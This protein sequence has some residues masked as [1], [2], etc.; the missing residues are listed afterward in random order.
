M[1][2]D[3]ALEAVTARLSMLERK[4]KPADTEQSGRF[5]ARESRSRFGSLSAAEQ[6]EFDVLATLQRELYALRIDL[7][8]IDIERQHSELA[9][10]DAIQAIEALADADPWYIDADE[11]WSAGDSYQQHYYSE[12]EER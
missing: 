1:N 6:H 9:F 4:V 10:I 11:G 2:I 7:T 5:V 12:D 8:E 3:A